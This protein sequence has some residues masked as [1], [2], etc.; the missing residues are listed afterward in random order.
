M[1]TAWG[2]QV[3]KGGDQLLD[4]VVKQTGLAVR[5]QTLRLN[6]TSSTV[7][8]PAIVSNPSSR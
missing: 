6:M 7:A 2:A 8:P 5:R 1:A 4:A 3:G